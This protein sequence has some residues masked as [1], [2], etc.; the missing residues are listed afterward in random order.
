[1]QAVVKAIANVISVK[2]LTVMTVG[3]TIGYVTLNSIMGAYI[4]YVT[5]DSSCGTYIVYGIY[6]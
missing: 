4:L 6:L 1:M 2:Y 3:I 5:H